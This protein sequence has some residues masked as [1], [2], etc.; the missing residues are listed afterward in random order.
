MNYVHFQQRRK[1]WKIL[2]CKIFFLENSVLK[3]VLKEKGLT[4]HYNANEGSYSWPSST[5][6]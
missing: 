1:A 2:N 5:M 4:Q 3:I 6:P